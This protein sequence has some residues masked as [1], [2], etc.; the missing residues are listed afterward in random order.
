MIRLG[1]YEDLETIAQLML[2]IFEQKMQA[3]Y[4]KEGQCSF[5]E[6]ISLN[7]LQK[8][9]LS[10]NIFYIYTKDKDIKGVIELES[11]YH[12]AFLFSKEVHKGIG[13]SLCEHAFKNTK[14]D[15]CTVGAFEEAL[16]FYKKLGF[17]EVS[18]TKTFHD[19]PFTLMARNLLT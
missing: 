9:F 2:D 8:R 13:K 18:E 15:I 10:N 7:S 4:T 6:L 16:G 3:K 19:L 12:I 17:I 1:E 5:K 14:E 11:P